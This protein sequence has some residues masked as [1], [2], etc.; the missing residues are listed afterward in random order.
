MT[1]IADRVREVIADQMKLDLEKV[2]PEAS[3][4]EDLG[5]DS[6]TNVE[7]IMALEEKFDIDIPDEDSQKI[8]TVNDAIKYVESKISEQT[9]A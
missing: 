5:A 8:A 4:T 7:L 9:E 1:N 2:K 3:F 6:L